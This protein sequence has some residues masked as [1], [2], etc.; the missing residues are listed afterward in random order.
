MGIIAGLGRGMPGRP[1]PP[2]AGRPPVRPGAPPSRP[3]GGRGGRS[4][5]SAGA[6]PV[7]RAAGRRPMPWDGANGL[8]PGRGAPGRA[9]GRAGGGPGRWVVSVL[10]LHGGRGLG[11]LGRDGR[12]LHGD[13]LRR[14]GL[15]GDLLGGTGTRAWAGARPR[16]GG[17]DGCRRRGLDDRSRLGGR[18]GLRGGL[19]GRLRARLCRGL[20]GGAL[21][22]TR[23]QLGTELVGEPLDHGGLDRRRRRLDE[24]SHFFELGQDDLALDSELFGE[25][26]DSDLS[27]ASPSGP[28]P[29][30]LDGRRGAVGPLA[31]VH[32]HR[33]VL[34]E[35]S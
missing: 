11:L 7:G 28:S 1:W 3:A 9:D 27:H 15:L 13:R 29:G 33:K 16:G 25:L 23:L 34:I 32:A 17:L 30:S 22:G 5:R 31:G 21:V 2:P 19:G 10:S 8:L 26:V 35:C 12:G 24:L 4:A 6:S 20:L 18:G 14:S